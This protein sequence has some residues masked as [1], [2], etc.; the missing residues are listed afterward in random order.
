MERRT[1]GSLP[2]PS[3][4]P[5]LKPSLQGNSPPLLCR[6]NSA[7]LIGGTCEDLKHLVTFFSWVPFFSLHLSAPQTSLRW[8]DGISGIEREVLFLNGQ[9]EFVSAGLRACSP[10]HKLEAA[11]AA[12]VKNAGGGTVLPIP[13]SVTLQQGAVEV[14]A[15]PHPPLASYP[16]PQSLWLG[17]PMLLPGSLAKGILHASVPHP[18]ISCQFWIPA[19]GEILMG[20]GLSPVAPPAEPGTV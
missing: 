2:A 6:L 10:D 20:V 8:K 4:K 12:Q 18:P 15:T 1:R 3:H 19:A 5:S 13:R 7:V 14:S 16:Q 11:L 17:H 9:P